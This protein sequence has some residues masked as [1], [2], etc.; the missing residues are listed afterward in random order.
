M[1]YHEYANDFFTTT[2]GLKQFN[3]ISRFRFL[4]FDGKSTL[5]ESNKTWQTDT[6]TN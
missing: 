2:M 3:F 6:L 1:W 5:E 4:Q